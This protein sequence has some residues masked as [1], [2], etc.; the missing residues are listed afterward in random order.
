MDHERR[1]TTAFRLHLDPAKEAEF[2]AAARPTPRVRVQKT[3]AK[4]LDRLDTTAVVTVDGTVSW[5]DLRSDHFSTEVFD[6]LAEFVRPGDYLSMQL[7]DDDHGAVEDTTI[8]FDGAGGWTCS[9]SRTALRLGRRTSWVVPGM[10]RQAVLEVR[11]A[12]DGRS[13]FTTHWEPE[14]GDASFDRVLS[15]TSRESMVWFRLME[16]TLSSE[17]GVRRR[18]VSA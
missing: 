14:V 4:A 11:I 13:L 17:G 8:T 2:C 1:T 3:F 10:Y 6:L 16:R 9:S 18:V 15:L 5:F 7:L 12:S